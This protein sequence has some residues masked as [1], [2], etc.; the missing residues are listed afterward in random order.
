MQSR[1]QSN[2]F[3][4]NWSWSQLW[5]PRQDQSSMRRKSL[6]LSSDPP[7][8]L[9]CRGDK[10]N[11]TVNI[12]SPSSPCVQLCFFSVTS[13]LGLSLQE[14]QATSPPAR[15]LKDQHA[16]SFAS[17]HQPPSSSLPVQIPSTLAHMLPPLSSLP[18]SKQYMVIYLLGSL[19][20][21]YPA[22]FCV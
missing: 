11:L 22:S 1:G 13:L 17:G 14:K 5:Y 9:H 21:N 12:A 3:S 19:N 18:W 15:P 7:H 6:T 20:T 4:W 8:K 16:V 2:K 10:S